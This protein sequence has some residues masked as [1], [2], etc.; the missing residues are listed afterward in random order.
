[1]RSR[2][3]DVAAGF[4]EDEF[5]E[6]WSFIYRLYQAAVGRRPTLSVFDSDRLQIVPTD[7]SENSRIAFAKA[8]VVRSEFL[9]KYPTSMKAD[10]FLEQLLSVMQ[11]SDVDLVSERGNLAALYDGTTAGRAQIIQ[12][13]ADHP[14]FAKK[15]SSKAFV[16]A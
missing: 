10:R 1:M 12:R 3:L 4:V 15:E 14:A 6:T 8:F 2:R 7:S 9:K 11:P 13:L 16:L 5:L